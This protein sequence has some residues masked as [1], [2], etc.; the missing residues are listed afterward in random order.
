MPER[1]SHIDAIAA[2]RNPFVP[3]GV[4]TVTD[5][6]P[7]PGPKRWYTDEVRCHSV[8]I[9]KGKPRDNVGH[10]VLPEEID[11]FMSMLGKA[12]PSLSK[13]DAQAIQ[14]WL[15]EKAKSIQFPQ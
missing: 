1:V 11:W 2:H 9:D 4:S 12:V 7:R 13:G 14:N 8:R 3:L 10:P 15:R 6:S 5:V